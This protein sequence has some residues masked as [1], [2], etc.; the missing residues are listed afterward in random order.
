MSRCE[1]LGTVI[2]G[3]ADVAFPAEYPRTHAA[4]CPGAPFKEGDREPHL[5]QGG[6]ERNTRNACTDHRE[7]HALHDS[8]LR[9]E[10]GC[11]GG[12]SAAGMCI[13]RILC[14][15]ASLNRKDP[16]LN[17]VWFKRDLRV[18]DHAALHAAL[19][20]S[21]RVHLPGGSSL[22]QGV[23]ALMLIERRLWR[24]E[25]VAAQHYHFY[26]ECC[27]DVC[28]ALRAR[29]VPYLM[30]DCED[31]VHAL[32]QIRC[33]LGAFALF[34]HMES[35]DAPSYARDRRVARWCRQHG[36]VWTEYRQFG[37][38]RGMRERKAWATQWERMM[39]APCLSAP[40]LSAPGLSAPGLIASG[41]SASELSAPGLSA[42]NPDPPRAE[43]ASAATALFQRQLA[44][45]CAL[46]GFIAS[47][48]T[49]ADGLSLGARA[50]RASELGLEPHDP[51]L[52][53]RGGWR[54]AEATLSNFLQVRSAS[55]RGGISSPLRA[56]HACSRLSAYL[57]FGCLSMRRVVH[58]A[59]AALPE[60]PGLRGFLERLHWHCHF[61]QKLETEPTIAWQNMHRG[62]D[63][64]R[65]SQFNQEHFDALRSGRTGW[66]MVDASVRMLDATG[67]INF[68]M[69]AMLVSVAAYPLW[70][71]WR[72]VGK[73]LATRFL[74][75]EPGIHW[76]Q[77]QMQSGTTGIN[78]MR[79]YN[80]IK[81]AHDQDPKGVFVRRWLEHLRDLP[82]TWLF[83]PWLA[84]AELRARFPIPSPLVDLAA[85]TR[86][87]KARV[88]ALR[89]NPEVIAEAQGVVRRHASKRPEARPLGQPERRPMSQPERLQSG[90]PEPYPLG[91]TAHA[92][93]SRAKGAR[94][95]R[96]SSAPAPGQLS[97]DFAS[98]GD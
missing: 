63:G 87:A 78:T 56:E 95:A 68:R 5:E 8:S 6:T 86:A 29:G 83:E 48:A 39:N 97:F 20:E 52:R 21:T 42:S 13:T 26:R 49:V 85:A 24:E 98:D 30:L 46:P 41:L 94:D 40:G 65:E 7:V 27:D 3:N 73:W 96:R 74:D 22:P 15:H 60:R 54:L 17:L 88:H 80:P 19:E 57:A 31:A 70:L 89:V 69:R 84:P 32:E 71:H 4:A 76:S 18:D 1:V 45:L 16:M 64:L 66:P 81:Q 11:S 9:S 53:Q 58:R 14:G 59:R 61:I 44:R 28:G 79:V 36:I 92:A 47:S 43:Y 35:G 50:P 55:Y 77:M 67:W 2:T 90:Q 62:Y 12:P 82:D 10:R 72:E 38:V 93:E 25:T 23:L 37:V 33:T 91:Q 51:P 75:Y 34:S